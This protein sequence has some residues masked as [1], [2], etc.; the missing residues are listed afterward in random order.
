VNNLDK[1]LSSF[2]ED[3]ELAVPLAAV[4][5]HASRAGG[6]SY[7]EAKEIVNDKVEEVLLVANE[8][9]L[10]IPTRVEKSSSWEDRQL[11]C[12]P[13]ESYELP[14]VVQYLLQ[15]AMK[16]GCW[17]PASAVSEVFKEIDEPA[18]GQIPELV[19]DL[20][21][22]AKHHRIS[23]AQVRQICIRLSLGDW[24]DVL[25]AEL[26]VTGIMSPKLSPL[27]EV[28]RVGSPLYELNPSLFLSKVG[29]E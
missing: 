20:G 13:G 21:K 22:Q 15:N 16:T 8:W 26:K 6:I 29:K 5:A 11:L 9:R 19:R 25:I 1:A 24:V 14:G 28:S 10:L 27:A 3:I 4:L 2:L 17:D 18:L 12:K 7:D 23:A